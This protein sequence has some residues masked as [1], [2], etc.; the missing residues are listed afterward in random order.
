MRA[1]DLVVIHCTATA[2]GK[3][4]ARGTPGQ[5][6][7]L[8]AAAVVNAWHAARGF[9]RTHA[10]S[11][12]YTP[13]LPSIGYHWVIDLDGT[14]QPGRHPCEVGAHAALFNA[15]SLG[16]SMVGGAERSGLYTPLQW[17]ALRTLVQAIGVA[18]NV[19]LA[20]PTRHYTMADAYTEQDGICGHRD[21]SPDK[22]G[23]GLVEPFEWL[24]TCP[25]FDVGQWLRNDLVPAPEHVLYSIGGL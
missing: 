2:S 3:P 6:G 14:V 7:Y 9:A 13:E 10:A 23:D 18:Y 25:G 19:P 16:V 4:I 24:K 12:V 20:P 5:P 11:K 22:D 8:S 15:R 21:L 1:I 17:E